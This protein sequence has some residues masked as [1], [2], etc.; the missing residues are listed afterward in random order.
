MDSPV[1]SPDGAVDF[2]QDGISAKADSN[3]CGQDGDPKKWGGYSIRKKSVRKGAID[4]DRYEDDSESTDP[5]EDDSSS[6]EEGEIDDFTYK[7][8]LTLSH[9]RDEPQADSDDDLDAKRFDPLS[10]E[11]EYM[12]DKSKAKYAKKYFKL[13][14]SEEKIR[15]RILEDAPIPGNH[16][17]NPPDV[18]DY[19]EDLVADHKSM[20]FLKMHDSSLKFVQKRVSQCMGPLSMIWDEMDKA[21]EGS[22]SSMEIEEVVNLLE[23]TILMIGQVNVACLY[24]RRLNFLAKILKSTK[25]AKSMLRENE[26]KLQD[27]SVLFGNDFYTTL[28]R[29]S[30]DRKRAREM[31]RDIARPVNKKPRQSVDQPFR[32]GPSGEQSPEGRAT[33]EAQEEAPLQRNREIQPLARSSG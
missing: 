28:Y 9:T 30:K 27:D 12:L 17:V 26:T 11:T 5:Y 16:F 31:S 4:K 25:K 13:H 19:L 18:D 20:K 7:S 33:Q 32:Q 8:P 2:G 6:D 23:K 29:K 15:S 22:K 14:L 10:D 1:C 21:H 24:E 3:L